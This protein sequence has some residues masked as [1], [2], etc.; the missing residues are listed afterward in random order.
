MEDDDEE[1][2]EDAD[3]MYQ[4][5][6]DGLFPYLLKFLNLL[7]FIDEEP[8]I[9]DPPWGWEPDDD[10]GMPLTRG[11]HHHHHHPRRIPSPWT[12]FPTGGP[13]DRGKSG[14]NLRNS[15]NDT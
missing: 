12:I 3:V 15:E 5:G 1:D 6:Y 13:S 7:N 4:P 14:S 9:P 2:E 10:E 8:G 11:H